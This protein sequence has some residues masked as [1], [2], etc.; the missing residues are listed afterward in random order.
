V[1]EH[2]HARLA[3]TARAAVSASDVKTLGRLCTED[4]VW[5]ASGRGP[6]SGDQHA[7]DG[8]WE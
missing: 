6:R 1:T 2:P 5:Q 8:F 7:V 4:P 3:R